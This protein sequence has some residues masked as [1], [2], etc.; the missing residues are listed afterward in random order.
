MG[1][2]ALL[3]N[4]HLEEEGSRRYRQR[5]GQR[6]A[7]LACRLYLHCWAGHHLPPMPCMVCRHL[8]LHRHAACLASDRACWMT[9]VLSRA[10]R[11]DGCAQAHLRDITRT[12]RIACVCCARC[13][14]RLRACVRAWY[15][16]MH[17]YLHRHLHAYLHQHMCVLERRTWSRRVRTPSCIAPTLCLNND[18][19]RTLL[20]HTP[21]MM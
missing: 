16:S 4:F 12:V 10:R 9:T 8:H 6:A 13:C 20:L 3:H 17:I 5:A 15:S 2:E 1:E 18:A 21:C 19:T 7:S 14:R 11:A